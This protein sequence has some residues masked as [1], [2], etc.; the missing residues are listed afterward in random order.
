VN[1][2]S[3]EEQFNGYNPDNRDRWTNRRPTL[4]SVKPRTDA[5]EL[6]NLIES[7]AKAI[8]PTMQ[9]LWQI[10]QPTARIQ[11]PG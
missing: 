1:S 3:G 10:V 7:N 4:G 11:P 5:A 8:Q 6:R 9:R 2:C